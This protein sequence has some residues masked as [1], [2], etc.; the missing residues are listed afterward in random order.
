[1]KIYAMVVVDA[2]TL[3]VADVFDVRHAIEDKKVSVS[4]VD[5]A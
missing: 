5:I 3:L 1:M 4:A 2:K